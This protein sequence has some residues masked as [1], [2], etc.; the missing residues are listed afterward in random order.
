M[1]RSQHEEALAVECGYWHLW[2]YNPNNAKEGKNPFTL[3]SKEPTGDYEAFIKG[4]ARY[5]RLA[6]TFPERAKELFE[7]ATETAKA[8]YEHLKKLADFYS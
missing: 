8:K 1:G 3:D 2:R 7:K 6:Q 5:A 4:E